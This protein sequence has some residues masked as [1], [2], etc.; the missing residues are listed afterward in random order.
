MPWTAAG[1]AG[2]LQTWVSNLNVSRRPQGRSQCRTMRHVRRSNLFIRMEATTN[3]F[4]WIAGAETF[5]GTNIIP[6]GSKTV[7]TNW[8]YM[9]KIDYHD[10]VDRRKPVE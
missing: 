10:R 2:Y 8:P 1:I 7:D 9:W 5:A 4:D 6:K 3:H